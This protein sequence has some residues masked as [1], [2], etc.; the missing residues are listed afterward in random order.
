MTVLS[1][2]VAKWFAG[3]AVG[4]LVLVGLYLSVFFA[5]Y[6]LFR[7]HAELSG[8][9]VYSDRQIGAE[10]ELVFEDARRRV[11]AMEL[12]D[13]TG[14]PRIFVCRSQRLFVLLTRLAGKRHAGQGLLISVAGNVFLSESGISAVARRNRTRPEHSRL[15]GSWSAAVAHEVAHYLAFSRLGYRRARAIPT[16]KSEGWADHE[17][18]RAFTRSDADD[19]FRGRVRL[20]L[21]ED[22]WRHPTGAIDRRHLRWHALVEYLCEV[23]GLGFDQLMD[24]EVTEERAWTDLLSW[25]ETTDI[26]TAS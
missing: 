6:P 3:V 10:F 4:T 21:D 9:R 2:K 8:F 14:L 16:W 20:L 18:N 13:G 26:S 11:E 1:R 24:P 23:D 17:A 22:A 5:P 19:D 25:Y 7:H 12:F 15:Q